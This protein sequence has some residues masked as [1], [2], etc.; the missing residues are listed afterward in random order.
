MLGF[1]TGPVLRAR[2]GRLA[3]LVRALRSHRRGRGFESPAAHFLPG[4]SSETKAGAMHAET[5]GHSFCGPRDFC[6]PGRCLRGPWRGIAR[7]CRP[8]RVRPISARTPIDKA[9]RAVGWRATPPIG[10]T[11]RRARR[12]QRLRK[13][14]KNRRDRLRPEPFSGAFAAPAAPPAAP[15]AAAESAPPTPDPFR[16]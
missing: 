13:G 12:I 15:P 10:A 5:R 11:L 8:V 1:C 14:R 3:Q 4:V 2:A 6:F 9:R 16:S 7:P